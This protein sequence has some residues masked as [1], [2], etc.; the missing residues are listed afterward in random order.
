MKVTVLPCFLADVLDHVLVNHHG[1]SALDKGVETVINFGLPRRGDLVVMALDLDAQLL[2]DQTHLGADVLL[3]VPRRNGE[4]ALFVPD[5]VAEIGH[6]VSAG[7]PDRLFRIDA[8]ERAVRFVVKLHV[9]E[10]EEFRFRPKDGRIGQSGAGKVLLGMGGDGAGVTIVGLVR[11]GIGDGAGQRQ[12]RHRAERVDEGGGWVWHGQHVRGLDGFP[13]ADGGA[14][15]AKPVGE[16]LFGE[17]VDWATEVLPGAKGIDEFDVHHFGPLFLGQVEG[18]PGCCCFYRF[19]FCHSFLFSF[20]GFN[21]NAVPVVPTRWHS[22]LQM[23]LIKSRRDSLPRHV[24]Q[25]PSRPFRPR[26]WCA[27]RSL[28]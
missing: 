23:S 12:R 15:K 25:D 5:F 19:V 14:V 10:N 18:A 22:F 13:T 24:R 1:V 9:I 26:R 28:P 16:D 4:I 11:A 21:R 8:I 3:G 6:L 17:L 2:H 7:V 20:S 27:D